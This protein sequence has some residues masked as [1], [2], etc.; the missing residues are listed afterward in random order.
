M[1]NEEPVS[2]AAPTPAP[3]ARSGLR[4]AQVLDALREDIMTGRL[5]SGTR[6]I[7][8]KIATDLST[9]RGPVREALRELEHE[10]LVTA[11]P[12]RGVVV[13]GVSDEEVFEVLIP[14]RMTLET[15]A[16][17]TAL[18][19][20]TDED[21]ADL[22]KHVWV[23][24]DAARSSDLTRLVEADLAFH[25]IV[26]AR[27]GR[28]HVLQLWRSIWPRIRGYF[29]RYGRLRPLNQTVSEHRQL[30]AAV[31]TRDLKI[32]LAALERHIVVLRPEQ[33]ATPVGLPQQGGAA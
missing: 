3:R 26:L 11:Y 28:P 4:R 1:K 25:E 16:F 6:L 18:H 10:G 17:T 21:F 9:S 32:V 2:G 29:F 14:I 20:L 33:A 27:S 13:S 31:Q 19:Q 8:E 22:A 7:E 30:L 15:F 12:Y 5:E 23:M 24:E